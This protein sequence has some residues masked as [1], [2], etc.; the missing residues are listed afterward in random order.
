VKVHFLTV[1]AGLFIIALIGVIC[2]LIA[3]GIEYLYY[4]DR[5]PTQTGQARN[6]S[7]ISSKKRRKE[8]ELAKINET[9]ERSIF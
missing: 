8:L 9:T 1:L 2:A 3:L 6:T 7:S 5:I 4:K